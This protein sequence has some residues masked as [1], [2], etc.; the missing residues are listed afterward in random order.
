[1]E[2]YDFATGASLPGHSDESTKKFVHM[3]WR[4]ATKVAFGV[5]DQYVIAFV[6]DLKGAAAGTAEANKVQ[7][8]PACFTKGYNSCYNKLALANHNAYRLAHYKFK[9]INLHVDAA[10]EI[11]KQLDDPSVGYANIKPKGSYTDCGQS[12]FEEADD[13]TK[14]LEIITKD[15]ASKNWYETGQADYSYDDGA[16]K[17]SVCDD[18][19]KKL[20][21]DNLTQLLWSSSQKVGFGIKGRNVVAWYCKKGNTGGSDK[22]KAY[23][24]NVG[25]KCVAEANGAD[26][27]FNAAALKAINLKRKDHGSKALIK[28]SDAKMIQGFMNAYTGTDM[29]TEMKAKLDANKPNCGMNIYEYIGASAQNMRILKNTDLAVQSWYDK[30][31]WYNFK[32]G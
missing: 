27:C 18:A 2:L 5:T 8:Q 17:A 28:G 6:C 24:A 7:V 21:V 23:K 1:M 30:Q 25:Q 20:Q 13:A 10:K 14:I 12:K 29:K 11:Q 26:E 3:V 22:V 19:T 31:M 16:C 9:Y 4:G 32:T 15:T